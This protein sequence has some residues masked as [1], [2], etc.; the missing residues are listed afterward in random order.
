MLLFGEHIL[1]VDVEGNMF[2]WAFKGIEQHS[3]PVG[4]IMLD[5]KFSPSCLVHPDTYLNKVTASSLFL[6]T[7]RCRS[8][9]ERTSYQ[10]ALQRR[11]FLGARKV[12]CSFGT[13]AQRKNFMSSRDGTRLYLVVFHRQHLMLLQS[14]VLMERFIFSTF[15]MMKS[16]LPSHILH[17]VPWQPYLSV[18]VRAW[19]VRYN[20]CN[21]KVFM[22]TQCHQGSCAKIGVFF[23]VDDYGIFPSVV[24]AFAWLS[25]LLLR[26]C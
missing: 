20:I 11:F 23:Y 3:A 22:S 21:C 1:S 17:E 9:L 26:F 5:D 10:E 2:I 18:L 24:Y 6:Q 4:H 7:F 12:L 16:W 8:F 19:G 25:K 13:L 15:G 14:A